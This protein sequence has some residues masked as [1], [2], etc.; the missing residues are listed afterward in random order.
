[1]ADPRQFDNFEADQ[2]A[3]WLRVRLM[4]SYR[5]DVGQK[6]RA[7]NLGDYGI[8]GH[9]SLLNG[10]KR[11]YRRLPESA[12]EKFK[13]GLRSLIRSTVPDEFPDEGMVDAIALIAL[14]NDDEGLAALVPVLTGDWS[15]HPDLFGHALSTLKG[16]DRSEKSYPAVEQL[17]LHSR[18]PP[19]LVFDALSILFAHSP[20]KWD[21][22]LERLEGVIHELRKQVG[23]DAQQATT[24]G[25]RFTFLAED[26]LEY[27]P[28]NQVVSGLRRL[29]QV[30]ANLRELAPTSIIFR[31]LV[32]G[33]RYGGVV[34]HKETGVRR[35]RNRN[36]AEEL[37]SGFTAEAQAFIDFNAPIEAEQPQFDV[38]EYKDYFK[39][40]GEDPNL[41]VGNVLMVVGVLK[42][43][44][45]SD[46]WEI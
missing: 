7:L 33:T 26:I 12:Q 23:D 25:E 24:L 45:S 34:T 32:D 43:Q 22:D 4:H 46:P 44:S 42:N 39:K 3:E 1:M 16:L 37:L 9:D 20:H 31:A 36:G 13:V 14:T 8:T 41:V 17:A 35:L 11:L 6:I 29:T 10:L 2:F 28:V 30:N 40:H 27:V 38:Q 19:T 18:F 15:T 5:G 21:V